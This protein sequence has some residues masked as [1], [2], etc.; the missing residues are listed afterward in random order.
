MVEKVELKHLPELAREYPSVISE[1]HIR[2]EAQKTIIKHPCLEPK[3]AMA[4]ALNMEILQ[5]TAATKE[6]NDIDAFALVIASS[7][8]VTSWDLWKSGAEKIK[9]NEQQLN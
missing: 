3:E 7:N 5:L 2:N 9:L 6:A 1:T 4:I 8:E